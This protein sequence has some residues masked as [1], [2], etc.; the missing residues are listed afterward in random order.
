MTRARDLAAFVSN[1]DGDIKFDTDTL[2]IDS[3]ANR[4]GIGLTN[5]TGSLHISNS[6][7]SFYMTDTTNNTEGVVSMDNAGS[8][9]LN[10][11]LNNEA[12]SSNIRFAVDG[13]ETM[14]IDSNGKVGIGVT[15]ESNWSTAQKALQVGT[16]AL[17]DNSA[18]DAFLG[19]NYYY[20][21][22]NNKYINSG[23]AAAIGLVDGSHIFYT[24]ASGSAD[25]NIS[26]SEKVRILQGGGLTFNGDTAAANAL[27]DYEEGTWT[28][29]LTFNSGNTGLSFTVQSGYY[30]KIGRHVFCTFYLQLSSKGSSTGNA[31]LVNF[32]F[33]TNVAAGS[34]GGGSFT[35][36]HATSVPSNFG[37]FMLLVESGQTEASLRYYNTSAA[38]MTELSSSHFTSNTTFF[39]QF[40]FM[41]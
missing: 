39:G 38:G 3:S 26:F 2:F 27:D 12:A 8:L 21:G 1:A 30:T 14:R 19:A 7:P 36:F 18:N 35:Y 24:A 37:Q 15:P 13:S 16:T 10:A 33:T 6:A 32:P 5:P 34:R 31:R 25:A 9:I 17:V 29:S 40:N 11:D 28:P 20:D 4:V 22:S 23:P 41:V